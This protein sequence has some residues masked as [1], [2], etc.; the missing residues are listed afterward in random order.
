MLALV[1]EATVSRFLSKVQFENDC[2]IWTGTIS[3]GYGQFRFAG[4]TQRAHRFGYQILVGE[5]PAGLVLDHLCCNKACVNPDHLEPVTQN[6][7]INRAGTLAIM[8]EAKLSRTHCKRGHRYD[9]KN[10]YVK[11]NG[12]RDCRQC[13]ADRRSERTA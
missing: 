9:S 1:N 10:T 4:A 8:R 12:A 3:R 2:W 6:E 11:R 5:I 13:K 7:N